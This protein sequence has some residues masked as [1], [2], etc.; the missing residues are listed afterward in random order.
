MKK[1]RT[2]KEWLSLFLRFGPICLVLLFLI[3]G[4]VVSQCRYDAKPELEFHPYIELNQPVYADIVS[5]EPVYGVSDDRGKTNS[6]IVCKCVDI[7]G[8]EI[9][10]YVSISK[11]Y[12]FFDGDAQLQDTDMIEYKAV[13]FSEPLRLHG[14][15]VV[16]D[17]VLMDLSD[18]IGG[19]ML[20]ELDTVGT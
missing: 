11:Y 19:E 5:I 2:F 13:E 17:L 20:L 4:M 3:I 12:Q 8:E 18:D 7:S 15:S 9:W 6:A 1:K 14:K 10:I 16:A